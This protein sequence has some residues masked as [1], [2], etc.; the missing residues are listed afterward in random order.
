MQLRPVTDW[1]FDKC[2]S[3]NILGINYSFK[4]RPR[5][6]DSIENWLF[7]VILFSLPLFCV[8]FYCFFFPHW[9]LDQKIWSLGHFKGKIRATRLSVQTSSNCK[10][11]VL[12][13]QSFSSLWFS[14]IK[15]LDCWSC[16]GMSLNYLYITSQVSSQAWHCVLLAYLVMWLVIP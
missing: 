3:V 1:S 9:V 4:M 7:Y 13:D 15:R 8:N 14:K 12:K 6:L 11:P 16:Q 2:V 10:G 5:T